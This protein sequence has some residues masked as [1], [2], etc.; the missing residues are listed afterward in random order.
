MRILKIS[1]YYPAY[2]NYIK[3]KVMPFTKSYEASLAQ[4]MMDS[5]ALADFYGHAFRK[6]GHESF[7]IVHNFDE[8]QDL[9]AKEKGLNKTGFDLLAE[10]VKEV[11]PDILYLDTLYIPPPWLERIRLEVPQIKK[12]GIFNCS[13]GSANGDELFKICDFVITCNEHINRQYKQRG[14]H[15]FQI[16]H[17]FD[18]RILEQLKV[19]QIKNQ[20]LFSGSLFAG[21][22]F[23]DERVKVLEGLIHQQLPFVA[24]ASVDNSPKWK[25]NLKRQIFL[26]A[27]ALAHIP[28]NPLSHWR[29]VRNLQKAKNIP[30]YLN[31]SK[32][33]RAKL[34]DPLFGIKMYQTMAESLITFNIHGGISGNFAA[35]M[36]MFEATGVGSCLLTDKKAD[37]HKLFDLDYEIVTYSSPQ[38]CVEKAAWLL[39]NPTKAR[40]IAL[41][42][43]KRTLKDHTY[44]QR[45]EQ[46][47]EIF[48]S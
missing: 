48:Q 40:K 27:K 13:P 15:S 9:Y 23:H 16:F 43:Q 46:L 5:F 44:E 38:E 7:E 4:V 42:G 26:T 29:K 45:A 39:N 2:L 18:R 12:V 22:D 32:E 17:A 20:V 34:Q 47:L 35:N 1:H 30:T 24:Y 6:L 28:G 31:L 36:R 19:E 3:Q 14:L 10:Q 37:L 25:V 11:K 41:A 8:L 33:L 21:S